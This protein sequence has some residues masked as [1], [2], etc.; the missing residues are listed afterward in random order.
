M[1]QPPY[2]QPPV[3]NYAQPFPFNSPAPPARRRSWIGW[4]GGL[5]LAVIWLLLRI[6]SN[7]T[8]S[9]DV[10][11]SE[12]A[13]EFD[14]NNVAEVAI[15]GDVLKGSFRNPVLSTGSPVPIKR[16]RCDVPTGS[17]GSWTFVQWVMTKAQGRPTGPAA[18]VR[19]E[20]SIWQALSLP[21]TLFPWILI[22]CFIWVSVVRNVRKVK[23]QQPGTPGGEP[24]RVFLVNSPAPAQ[25]PASPQ[26]SP[27]I[28]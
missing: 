14:R 5:G 20:Q 21:L 12:L 19:V 4:I 11:L 8:G 1:A 24:L 2:Q 16:F 18:V 25:P 7:G 10:A 6:T 22:V 28:R 13:D 17:A 27:E 23:N 9:S 3:I 26:P 15:D